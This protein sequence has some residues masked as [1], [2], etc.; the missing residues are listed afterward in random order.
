MSEYEDRTPH[1][2]FGRSEIRR[3]IIGLLFLDL[4]AR[5]HLREIARRARTSAGTTSREL[6]RLEASGL[7]ERSVEGR[8]SYF[9]AARGGPVARAVAEIVR[10]TMGAT[11]VLRAALRDIAGIESA[12]VFGSCA[13]G[14]MTPASDIDLLVVGSPDRD[15]L[16]ERLELAGRDLGRA[17]NEVVMTADEL[18]ARRGRG[19]GFVRSIDAGRVLEVL[20]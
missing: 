2:L 7:V 18:A 19:D 11:V 13:G 8:Q 4:D 17:V 15:L 10:H 9:R 20:P 5:L 6:R 12:M 16:T 1:A 3:R 14:T